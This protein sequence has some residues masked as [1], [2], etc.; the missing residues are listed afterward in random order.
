MKVT[1]DITTHLLG[2]LK[3]TGLTTPSAEKDTQQLKLLFIAGR[4]ANWYKH[5]ERQWQFQN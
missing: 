5:F 1:M 3:F 2:W 4:N